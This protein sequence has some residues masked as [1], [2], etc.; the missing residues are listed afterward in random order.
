MRY[1]SRRLP[2]TFW[3]VALAVL[4]IVVFNVQGWLVFVRT[5]R[6]LENELGDRLQ[7]VGMTLSAALGA[8]AGDS[9]L[10]GS[11]KLLAGVMRD[12]GLFN[13]FVV[14]DRLEYVV[15]LRNT[16]LRSNTGAAG[17]SDPTL[18]LDITEILAAFSGIP[19]QSKLYRHGDIYLKSAY[20]PVF[21]EFGTAVAVLGVEADAA[22]FA[23]LTGFRN[24]LLLVNGLSFLA[25][26]VI[27]LVS[28]SLVRYALRVEQA[29]SRANTLAL[30]GQMSA[31][32]AHEIKNPLG[33]IRASAERLRKKYGKPADGEPADPTFSYIEE[34]VD[35]LSQVVS[36]YL[37]LGKY[38]PGEVESLDVGEILRGVVSD[39]D[40]QARKAGVTFKVK[41]EGLPEVQGNRNELRQVFLNL[42]LNG[43]QAQPR[44]GKIELAAYQ[45]KKRGRKWLVVRVRD[46]GPGIPA[47]DK[48][49]LFEPFFTTREKGSGLGLFVVKR[50]VE[51]HRGRV[52]IE[53]R[54]DSGT[55]VEVRLPT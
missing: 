25:I 4:V 20:A 51:A 14:N 52:G 12:N 7:A 34:E 32:V 8:R 15:N 41:L 30:M 43:I 21:D 46:D 2:F 33:I 35:R 26:V 44:G 28:V 47:G 38:R 40:H 10:V 53:S 3:A 18:D 48:A 6:V 55:V 29:A 1:R 22:F 42:I 16:E 31:A 9:T 13:L 50:I 36:N 23:V 37:G 24:S 17:E 5:S 49:R 45:E 54:V 19:T 11:E 27:V 39:L